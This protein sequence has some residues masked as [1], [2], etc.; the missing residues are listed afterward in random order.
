MVATPEGRLSKY[1]YG[2]DYAPRDIR[3]ALVQ[4]SDNKIGS[5]VDRLLLYCYHYDPTAGKYGLAVL[6]LVRLGGVLTL[7]VLGAFVAISW[8]RDRRRPGRPAVPPAPV[9]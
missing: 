6:S 8:R 3:L 7:V 2:I 4:A 5:P 1:L 9:A